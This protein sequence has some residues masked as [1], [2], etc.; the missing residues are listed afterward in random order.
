M[1]RTTWHNPIVFLISAIVL[2]TRVG[3]IRSYIF[4]VC[5]GL[6]VLNR[7]QDIPDSWVGYSTLYTAQPKWDFTP[8]THWY[9]I[10]A[11]SQLILR[12]QSNQSL[13]YP[14]N[15]ILSITFH[16]HCQSAGTRHPRRIL[17]LVR[18]ELRPQACGQLKLP[19]I[20]SHAMTL[21]LSTTPG[22]FDN[23]LSSLYVKR[24]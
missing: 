1:R 5:I 23:G 7:F 12:Q 18:I 9:D 2:I 15:F 22:S 6:N 8:H 11:H 24:H 3:L 10:N 19:C 14:L 21:Q 4:C 16:N 13:N 17:L 20:L